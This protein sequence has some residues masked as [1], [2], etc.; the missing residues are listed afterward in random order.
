MPTTSPF[1]FEHGLTRSLLDDLMR[2]DPTSDMWVGRMHSMLQAV[3][4]ALVELRDAGYLVLNE[5]SFLDA[6]ALS[7]IVELA[8]NPFLSDNARD[9]VKQYLMLL[10]NIGAQNFTPDAEMHHGFVTM[11]VVAIVK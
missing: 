11:Q 1:D 5:A 9:N 6:M 3:V 8:K 4:P 7:E 2:G 10:P